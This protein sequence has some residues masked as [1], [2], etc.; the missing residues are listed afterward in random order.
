MP[1]VRTVAAEPRGARVQLTPAAPLLPSATY[2]LKSGPT[3]RGLSQ[4]TL[5]TTWRSSFSTA[6]TAATERPFLAGVV[7]S[8]GLVSGGDSVELNGED[9]VPGVRV[10]VGGV[11]RAGAVRFH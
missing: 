6:S 11:A 10:E 1:I 4:A 8:A 5:G 3:L 2:T 9:F 7:P